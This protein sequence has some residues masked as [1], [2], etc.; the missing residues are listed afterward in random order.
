MIESE[1][2]YAELTEPLRRLTRKNARFNWSNE[3]EDSYRKIIT[4]MTSDT[5]LRPFDPKLNTK[6]VTDAAPNGIAASVFQEDE[7]GVWIPVDHA[8]RSLTP[9][10]QN[11]S[12]I[13]KESLGQAWGMNEHRHYL[14]GIEF[15][16]YTDHQPLIPIYSANRR[17]NARIE[18]HRLRVQGFQYI[19]KHLPGKSNP[20]DYPSRHPIP[21]ESYTEKQKESMVIDNDDELCISK[22][23]TDDLPDAVTLK[24]IQVGTR[25]DA[26]LQGLIKALEKGF[27]PNDNTL[28]EYKTV[29]NEL[30][31]TDQVLLRGDRLVIP[32]AELY[33]GSGS[34]RQLV[35]DNAHEGHQ[36]IVK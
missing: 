8:S 26:T 5:A 7:S 1:N 23:I 14:L 25:E 29:F 24:M 17:G 15:E 34:L 32:D 21:L 19:M 6:L 35:V 16:S 10:E 20:C 4:A 18:R 28:R 3:C 9:C 30:T 13:E 36:G 2:A 27:L 31:Y 22:L 11:Y 33:P 12:Q